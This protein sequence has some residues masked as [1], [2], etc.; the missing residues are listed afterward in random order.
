[1]I[2][3]IKE[4]KFL[5]ISILMLFGVLFEFS[6]MESVLE[7]TQKDFM[8]YRFWGLFSWATSVPLLVLYYANFLFYRR[9]FEFIQDK[10]KYQLPEVKNVMNKLVGFLYFLLAIAVGSYLYQAKEPLYYSLVELVMAFSLF[11][12][13]VTLALIISKATHQ[14][15]YKKES[16]IGSVALV[17]FIGSVYFTRIL[18]IDILMIRSPFFGIFASILMNIVLYK[19]VNDGKFFE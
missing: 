19:R 17:L 18:N 14:I 12:S 6:V 8:T 9:T 5:W 7:Y 15:P 4:T 11:V 10:E 3:I 2:K 16:L 1:M 13:F